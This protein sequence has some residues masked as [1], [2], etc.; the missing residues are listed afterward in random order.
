MGL[1]DN[2]FNKKTTVEA[3]G[4]ELIL[5]NRV[6]DYVIIPKDRREEVQ[7]MIDDDCHSCIDRVVKTLPSMSDYAEDGTLIIN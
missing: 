4:S 2:L 5:K 6:G 3:E 1:F 7:K